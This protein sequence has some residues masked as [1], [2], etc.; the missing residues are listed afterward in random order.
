[1]SQQLDNHDL[2]LLVSY[3]HQQALRFSALRASGDRVLMDSS[4]R[5]LF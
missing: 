5:A 1:M 2:A 3:N 4:L